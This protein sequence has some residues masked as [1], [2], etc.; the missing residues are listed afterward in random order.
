MSKVISTDSCPET[1]TWISRVKNLTAKAR[2]AKTNVLWNVEA[3]GIV[4]DT[5]YSYL[6]NRPHAKIMMDDIREIIQPEYYNSAFIAGG[7]AAYVAGITNTYEDIDIF[8]TRK[9]T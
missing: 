6:D 5:L 4:G 7:F 8:C 3:E 1:M 9:S 2:R